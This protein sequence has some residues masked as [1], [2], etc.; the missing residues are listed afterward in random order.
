[1]GKT[2]CGGACVDTKTDNTHC[3]MCN[4]ACLMGEQCTESQCCKTGEMVCNGVCKN[5]LSDAQNCGMC[6]K[7][8][9]GG[10]PVCVAGNCVAGCADPNDVQFGGKCYYLNGT[11]GVCVQGYSKGSNAQLAAI[12]AANPNAWQGKNYR[13]TVSSNCCVLTSDNVQNYGMGT[14]CNSNGP[15]SANEPLAGGAGCSNISPPIQGAG[16]LTLCAS[17]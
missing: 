1:M 3:G 10:T 14:H 6:G 17:N 11:N 8:C 5:P 2:E 12:L 16:Q 15:F 9:S 7:V 4:K 13:S